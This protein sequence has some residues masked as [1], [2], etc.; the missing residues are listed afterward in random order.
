[1]RG[2]RVLTTVSTPRKPSLARA[3]K[4]DRLQEA[5]LE[6]EAKRA[7]GGRGVE[8]VYDSVSRTTLTRARLARHAA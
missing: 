1:M 3:R 5:G 4:G 2:A 6:A 8:V 7:T